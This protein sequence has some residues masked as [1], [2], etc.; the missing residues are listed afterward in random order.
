MHNIILRELMSPDVVSVHVSA[1]LAD[2]LALMRKHIYSCIV[3]LADNN[4]VGIITERDLVKVLAEQLTQTQSQNYGVKD[5]MSQPVVCIHEMSTL[6]EALVVTQ[7][8]SIRHLPVVDD[9]NWLVGMITQSDIARA[10]FISVERQRETIEQE[11]RDRTKHVVNANET[12]KTLALQDSLL[13]IGNRRAME[14]DVHFTHANAVRYARLYCCAL[15]DV[16]LFKVYNDCYG[17]QAGDDILRQVSDSIKS[18]LR[19]SD[20]LYRY[21]GEEFLALMPE[22]TLF[23]AVQAIYRV[24]ENLERLQLPHKKSPHGVISISVGIA[25]S[26][27]KNSWKEVVKE[28]DKYL[29]DAKDMGRNQVCWNVENQPELGKPAATSESKPFQSPF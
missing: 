18:S 26:E 24:T 5:I 2:V 17:H 13:G 3:V 4:P 27:R 29:Y 20:R 9:K 22:T 6:Y 23:E 19:C 12:L 14:V 1:T 7:S 11:I 21:G 16:D 10:H 8:R 15:I 25:C 28:A